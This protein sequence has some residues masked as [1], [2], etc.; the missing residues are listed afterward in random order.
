MYIC[1]HEIVLRE[2]VDSMESKGESRLSKRLEFKRVRCPHL[3]GPQLG[4]ALEECS[5]LEALARVSFIRLLLLEGLEKS[6]Y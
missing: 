3:G 2:K 5:S 4:I 6:L 1:F